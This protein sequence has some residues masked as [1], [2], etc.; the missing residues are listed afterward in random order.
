MN[1]Y[2]QV[3]RVIG[4]DVFIGIPFF[5]SIDRYKYLLIFLLPCNM[6]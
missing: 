4:A 2:A 1:R 6:R 3:M 5:T